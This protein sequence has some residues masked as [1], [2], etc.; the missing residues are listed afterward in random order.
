MTTFAKAAALAV[1]ALATLTHH[2]SAAILDSQ[3]KTLVVN[4]YSTSIQWPILLQQ[5]LDDYYGVTSPADRVITVDRAIMP[6]NPLANWIDVTTGQPK[7]LWLDTLRPALQA[8]SEPVILLAQQTLQGVY[9]T[10][11]TVG[12]EGPGD[13]ARIEQGADAFQAYA[14]L[15]LADGADQ[16]IIATHIYK[17]TQEPEIENEKYALAALLDRGLDN[18]LAGPDV[19]SAT[20]PLYPIGFQADQVHPNAIGAE[21][22]AQAWFDH[23]VTL[24]VPEPSTALLAGVGLL[25][26]AWRRRW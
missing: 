7:Q 19:W 14:E 17:V 11:R 25:L 8:P 9:S 3:P 13:A 15:A 10:D 22:M 24:S 26:P 6:G 2:G 12:I 18:V 21:A 4:G 16:V 23:L 5:K 20:E 1:V